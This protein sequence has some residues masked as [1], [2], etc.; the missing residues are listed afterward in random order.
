MRPCLLSPAGFT[1]RWIYIPFGSSTHQ[2]L[3]RCLVRVLSH[4]IK[5]LHRK[6]LPQTIDYK[7]RNIKDASSL[8]LSDACG[9][10]RLAFVSVGCKSTNSGQFTNRRI[11]EHHF[12]GAHFDSRPQCDYTLGWNSSLRWDEQQCK[13]FSRSHL[14]QC[15]G[16][17]SPTATFPIRWVCQLYFSFLHT[18]EDG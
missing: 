4:G 15:I 3:T 2:R 12:R 9:G 10:A 13:S 11:N 1:L 18:A 6:T 14:Y 17:R 16:R 7:F 8:V 5:T